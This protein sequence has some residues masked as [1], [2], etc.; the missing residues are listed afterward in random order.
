[1]GIWPNQSPLFPLQTPD[2]KRSEELSWFR[3]HGVRREIL[4]RLRILCLSRDIEIEKL[5]TGIYGSTDC[6]TSN[7]LTSRRY[8][9]V[10]M[11]ADRTVPPLLTADPGGVET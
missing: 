4:P 10:G 3:L 6:H 9:E 11:I 1:M 5:K 7:L 2:F 8:V